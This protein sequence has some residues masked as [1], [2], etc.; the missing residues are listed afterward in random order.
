MSNALIGALRVVLG[1]DTALFDKGLADSMKSLKGIGKSMQS[2]G[3]SM[4]TFVTAPIAGFGALTIKTA[5]DFEAAMNRVDAASGATAS[6]FDAMRKM[7]IKLGADTTF[8]ASESADAMEMLAKNGLSAGQILDGAVSSSMKL[9]AASGSDL[10]SAAD[11]ATAVMMNFGKQAKDLGPVVDGITGVL[12]QS[13]FGFDDYRL[14]IAQAGGVAGNVGVSFD[15]FN[16][17]IAATSS[18]FGSGSDAGTS[19][20]TFLVNLVPQSKQATEAM[21][22]LGLE[23]FNANG[24]MKSMSEIAEQLQSK[25]SGL[26]DEQLNEDMKT[27]F[28]TDAMRTAI[29]LMKQGGEGIDAFKAKIGDASA[30]EQ[31]AARLKGF[32]GELEQLKGAFETLQI[33]IA[34]SGL[35]ASVTAFVSKLAEWI[36]ALSQTNPQLLNWG[37]IIA[38]L[39]AVLGP[40]VLSVGLLATGIAAIG[41]PVAAAVAGIAALTAAIIAFWPEI[42]N[43]G[44]AINN[45]LI[46]ALNAMQAAWDGMIAKVASVKASLVEFAASIPGIFSA[47]ASKMVA[48]G[49]QIIQGLWDGLKSKMAA[50]R[51][52]LT[53]FASD[54]VDS[55]KNTL[56]IHSPSKVMAEIGNNIMEGL[57]LGMEEKQAYVVGVTADTVAKT[58]DAW[59]GMRD[60]TKQ[61]A[62]AFDNFFSGIGS[63][64]AEVIKGTKSLSDA[65]KDVLSQLGSSLLQQGLQALFGGGGG[66]GIGGLL[67]GLFGGL[68]GFASGGT[69]MPGGTGGIDSQLV[70]FRKSPNERVDISKPGQ[71]VGSGMN[72][73]VTLD[74]ELL[75][76]VITDEAGNV[77]GRA[78]PRIVGTAVNQANSNVVPTMARHQKERANS[79]YRLG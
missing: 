60:V 1:L 35:L 14:A 48:I 43:V 16:A 13:K 22:R 5:G 45:S 39:A 34:D 37:V 65:L 67:S 53:G 9:A 6:E 29:M 68:F 66:G 44:N 78:A 52:S 15:D 3:K 12:L 70:A 49:A 20:K 54:M 11:V 28:G 75:R 56:G 64:I 4:S 73:H 72:V 40:V 59:A 77:V 46:G 19:F 7:A 76:A 31:A 79:D 38:G 26:S 50:V 25:M 32:N 51:D 74:N 41:V 55:V 47:L 23:F 21:N 10:S 27:I 30:E 42:Q 18:A 2:V 17:A 8:S 36:T 61:T 62:G 69:I 71:T 57:G 33:A 58:K 63:T 24:S